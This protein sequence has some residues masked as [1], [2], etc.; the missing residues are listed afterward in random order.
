MS[1]EEEPQHS[2]EPEEPQH[3]NEPRY[4]WTPILAVFS[5]PNFCHFWQLYKATISGNFISCQMWQQL[6][7]NFGKSLEIIIFH[8]LAIFG[9]SGCFKKCLSQ[10]TFQNRPKFSGL[11]IVTFWIFTCGI[12]FPFLACFDCTQNWQTYYF[13]MW[14]VLW[15][16]KLASFVLS[17]IGKSCNFHNWQVFVFSTIGKFCIFHNW[18]VLYFP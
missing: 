13:Q 16:Q 7:A 14:Q 3:S 18:Q 5:K 4:V 15:L 11:F 9:T 17:I 12:E 1:R 6:S 10:A 8:V 2:N